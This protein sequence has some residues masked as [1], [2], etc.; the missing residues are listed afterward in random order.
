MQT[1]IF[2]TTLKTAKLYA[3]SHLEGKIL[4]TFDNVPTVKIGEGYYE[5]IQRDIFDDGK[6]GINSV[7][8]VLRVGIS[9]TNM[10][11]QR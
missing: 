4:M 10:I 6:R 9:S 2:D 1:L 5:V 8:P 7:F 11:I 3:G